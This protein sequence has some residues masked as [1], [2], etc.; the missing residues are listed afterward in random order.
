MAARILA[1]DI[2][3]SVDN[4][5]F[6]IQMQGLSAG[7][8]D[9]VV[10]EALVR[11]GA[12]IMLVQWTGSSR[13]EVSVPWTEVS[14]FDALDELAAALPCRVAQQARR[15]RFIDDDGHVAQRR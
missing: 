14:G 13:Q 8:R 15:H 6:K 5:E 1:V 3:G 2:S 7:L 12:H 10:A 11:G 4:E 9:G